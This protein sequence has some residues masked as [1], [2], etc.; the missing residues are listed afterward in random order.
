MFSV[1]YYRIAAYAYRYEYPMFV[2]TSYSFRLSGGLVVQ[3]LMNIPNLLGRQVH[4]SCVDHQDSAE[5]LLVQYLYQSIP[6][7]NSS[8]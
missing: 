4:F 5:Q 1:H 2:D 3:L 8:C 7:S 6:R